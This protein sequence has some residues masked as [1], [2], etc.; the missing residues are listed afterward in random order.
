V[1][2]I[3]YS[4]RVSAMMSASPENNEYEYQNTKHSHRNTDS[5]H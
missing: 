2:I 5:T 4:E 3:V 1:K